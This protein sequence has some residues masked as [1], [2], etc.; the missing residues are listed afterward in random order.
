MNLIEIFISILI[1]LF[2]LILFDV[3]MSRFS[4]YQDPTDENKI[5]EQIQALPVQTSQTEIPKIIHHMY[6]KERS[7]WKDEW[8]KCLKSW[9]IH[10]PEPEWVHLE[11]TDENIDSFMEE[12][13]QWFLPIFN[14][15]SEKIMKIDMARYFILYSYGGLYADADYLCYK[16]FW[17]KLDSSRPNLVGSPVIKCE[18]T[19]NSLMASPVQNPFWKQVF[20]EAVR[21]RN[22]CSIIDQTG[23]R[24]LDRSAEKNWSVVN[25]LPSARFNPPTVDDSNRDGVFCQHLITGS[26]KNPLQKVKSH[27]CD[28][29]FYNKMKNLCCD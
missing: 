17:N 23:P 12:S 8:F 22:Y 18:K 9:K 13:F 24:L 15:Y 2:F 28:I 11:W 29:I 21:S 26:W 14:K 6:P 25:I 27:M 20:L 19:Q 5:I 3:S 10:F 16:N 7:K 1:I 4:I